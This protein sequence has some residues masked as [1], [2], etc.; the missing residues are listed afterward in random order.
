MR[1]TWWKQIMPT[2]RSLA[3]AD[4]ALAALSSL[5]MEEVLL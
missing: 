5:R 4:T 2:E 3:A 1:L